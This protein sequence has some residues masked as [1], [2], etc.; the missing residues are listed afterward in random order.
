MKM[1]ELFLLKQ[2]LHRFDDGWL[3]C[4]ETFIA[5]QTL[6]LYKRRNYKTQEQY[7][8]GFY[9]ICGKINNLNPL[10]LVPIFW[11]SSW[12]FLELPKCSISFVVYSN[13]Q[14]QNDQ[15]L[16]Q[17][18]VLLKFLRLPS[19]YLLPLQVRVSFK[20]SKNFF[21]KPVKQISSTP[22]TSPQSTCST[23]AKASKNAHSVSCFFIP[24][25]FRVFSVI[26]AHN[27]VPSGSRTTISAVARFLVIW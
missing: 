19:V 16:C 13:D 20:I 27:W 24:I 21:E 23:T 8:Y 25:C 6:C 12:I 14:G 3:N 9:I 10:H 11:K 17:F 1:S 15:E 7:I 22:M 26:I 4:E 5:V 2:G 18:A